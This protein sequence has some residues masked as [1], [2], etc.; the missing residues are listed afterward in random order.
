VTQFINLLETHSSKQVAMMQKIYRILNISVEE[1]T[2][3]DGRML[4]DHCST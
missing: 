3:A 1:K 2:I 4:G